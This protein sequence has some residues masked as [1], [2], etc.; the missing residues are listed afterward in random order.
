MNIRFFYHILLFRFVL[1]SQ[2]YRELGKS[3]AS[4]RIML[5]QPEWFHIENLF[6]NLVNET[7]DYHDVQ[8]SWIWYQIEEILMK[9]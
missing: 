7:F 6:F 4:E 8:N 2:E 3:A 5:E 1:S 9:I